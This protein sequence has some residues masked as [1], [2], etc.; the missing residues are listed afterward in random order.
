MPS[1]RYYLSEDG[2]LFRRRGQQTEL[3][4]TWGDCAW[5][6]LLLPDRHI[7]RRRRITALRAWSRITRRRVQHWRFLRTVGVR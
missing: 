1:T 3:F 5:V 7:G 2:G 6:P 4:T